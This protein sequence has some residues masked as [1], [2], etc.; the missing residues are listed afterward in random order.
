LLDWL[1]DFEAEPISAQGFP[2]FVHAG[3]SGALTAFAPRLAAE[4]QRQRVGALAQRPL[5]ITGHSKGG[6]VATLA[7]WQFQ[8]LGGTPVKAVTFAGAKPGDA[9]FRAAYDPQIDH[10]RYEYNNDIV[11]HLP[12]SQGGFIDVLASI[13]VVGSRFQGLRRF[14]YQPVGTLRYIDQAGHLHDDDPMLR[15]ERDLTLAR[16]IIRLHLSDRPWPPPTPRTYWRPTRPE[17]E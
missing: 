11:P 5:L 8:A 16:E 3:F 15:A 10:T 12:L 6:A 14:D 2:G 1:N 17:R 13:P 9:A 7:A 4:V